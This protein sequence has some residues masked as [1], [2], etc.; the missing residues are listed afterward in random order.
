MPAK[1][2]DGAPSVHAVD[3]DFAAPVFV[4]MGNECRLSSY[5]LTDKI[6]VMCCTYSYAPFELTEFVDPITLLSILSTRGPWVRARHPTIQLNE[7]CAYR[8]FQG[9]VV[10]I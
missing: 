3:E 9:G 5:D 4:V 8:N 2:E 10:F 6:I 1:E 7:L